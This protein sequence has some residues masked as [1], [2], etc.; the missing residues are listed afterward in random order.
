M[1]LA[2]LLVSVL[3]VEACLYQSSFNPSL[4]GH[5]TTP[6]FSFLIAHHSAPLASYRRHSSARAC[7]GRLPQLVDDPLSEEVWRWLL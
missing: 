5:P 2:V 3:A 4:E 6:H 1:V 7:S